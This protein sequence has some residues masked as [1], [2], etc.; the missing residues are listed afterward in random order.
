[1]KGLRLVTTAVGIGQAGAC[2]GWIISGVPAPRGSLFLRVLPRLV[3]LDFLGLLVLRSLLFGLCWSCGLSLA[4]EGPKTSRC[5]STSVGRSST[6]TTRTPITRLNAPPELPPGI[7]LRKSS[8]PPS[9]V[10]SP[11]HCAGRENTPGASSAPKDPR[12]QFAAEC[13]AIYP[14]DA[15]PRR[16]P[17]SALCRR[18]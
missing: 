14:S 6:I 3:S 2:W 18:G 9:L 8:P 17:R 10:F 11:A 1:M 16:R 12:P 4:V 7:P 13:F 15:R 5:P